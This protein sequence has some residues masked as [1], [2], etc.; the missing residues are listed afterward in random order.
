[1]VTLRTVDRVRTY[2][3]IVRGGTAGAARFG[4]AVAGAENPWRAGRG[5]RQH[6][7]MDEDDLSRL[8]D[9]AIAWAEGHLDSTAYATRCLAFVEDAY[10]RANGLELFGGDTAHESAV[11]Y[12]AATRTG[13]PPRGAFVFY[14]GVGELLGARRN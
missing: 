3:R 7:R 5:S 11:L 4:R 12:E 14:D 13:P 2:V 9:H 10:E 6:R 8:A 1:M